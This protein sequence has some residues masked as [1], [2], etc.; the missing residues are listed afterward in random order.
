MTDISAFRHGSPAASRPLNQQGT[1]RDLK[2]VAREFETVFLTEMLIAAGAG[3]TPEKFGGGI[4]EEQF[5]SF[6]VRAQAEQITA[7]GGLGLSEIVLRS[8]LAQS[9]PPTRELE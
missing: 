6:L 7:R 4:G 1:G 2:A 3:A 9:T 5:N 8:V